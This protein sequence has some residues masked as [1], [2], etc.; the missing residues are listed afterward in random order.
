MSAKTRTEIQIVLQKDSLAAN[1]AW[2]CSH[3]DQILK[4]ISFFLKCASHEEG[5]YR[6]IC[7]WSLVSAR[8][9]RYGY[10]LSR[11][12]VTLCIL[13][14]SHQQLLWK[15]CS[16]HPNLCEHCWAVFPEE[17]SV[18]CTC[19]IIGLGDMAKIFYPDRSFNILIT[20]FITI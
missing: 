20:I 1:V 7:W 3:C 17:S 13:T 4:L 18:W 16:E 12:I 11:M 8:T 5:T 14:N 2:W 19:T 10:L 6:M 15:S 9:I